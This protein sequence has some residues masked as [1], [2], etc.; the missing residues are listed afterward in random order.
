M[1]RGLLFRLFVLLLVA[2]AAYFYFRREAT[3]RAGLGAS[4]ARPGVEEQGARPD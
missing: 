1:P 4:P 2:L 3:Q